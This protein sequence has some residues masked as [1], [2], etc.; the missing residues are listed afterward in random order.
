MDFALAPSRSDAKTNRDK[1]LEV[2]RAALAADPAASLNSI[3]KSAL[4]GPGTLYRHFPTREALIVAV[5]RAEIENL[6]AVS[7]ELTEQL[8]PIEAF[9]TWC[10][11]LLVHVRKQRGFAE[12]LHAA[13]TEQER[14]NAYRPVIGAI[15]HL[16][17][18]CEAAGAI[19]SGMDPGDIQL[20]LGFIWQIRSEEGEH[21]ARRGI[22]L[23]IRGLTTAERG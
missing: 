16:L 6:I 8:P 14:V 19:Q 17:T 22:D 2:A 7:R 13:L 3:A 4:L 18:V 1:L 12:V 10:H 20:L 23:I 11:R 15:A 21:R 5:Y 9:R